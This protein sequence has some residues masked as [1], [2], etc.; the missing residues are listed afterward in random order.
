[1]GAVERGVINPYI[2]Y[3]L[4]KQYTCKEIAKQFGYTEA[5]LWKWCK[6]NGVITERLPTFELIEELDSKTPKE[7]AYEYNLAVN[8]IYTRLRSIGMG[9]KKIRGTK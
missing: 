5:G 2:F 8:T 4:R 6:R 7:I 3:N 1:M 9:V